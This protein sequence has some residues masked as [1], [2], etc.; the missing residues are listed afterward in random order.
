MAGRTFA[1]WFPWALLPPAR[2]S[3]NFFFVFG[4]VKDMSLRLVFFLP[5]TK[6]ESV[7]V[8]VTWWK[9]EVRRQR[10]TFALLRLCGVCVLY[11]CLAAH[12]MGQMVSLLLFDWGER[13]KNK[14]WCVHFSAI[15]TLLRTRRSI[16]K[17]KG[18]KTRKEI[19]TDTVSVCAQKK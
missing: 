10:Q 11:G 13:R 16:S 19:K 2:P 4:G 7:L 8:C 6:S 18:N 5:S 1:T 9:I 12:S 15:A 14:C 3:V 17:K